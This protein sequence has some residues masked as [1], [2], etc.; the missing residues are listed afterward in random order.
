VGHEYTAIEMMLLEQSKTAL[1]EDGE[2]KSGRTLGGSMKLVL[3]RGAKPTKNAY[4]AR[5]RPRTLHTPYSA[6]EYT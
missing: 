3:N 2:K 4:P 6:H 5:L 1:S